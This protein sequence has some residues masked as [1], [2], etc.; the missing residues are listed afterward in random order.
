MPEKARIFWIEDYEPHI[1]I[2]DIFLKAAGHT[3]VRIASSVEEAREAIPSLTDEG[4]QVVIMDGD[5]SGRGNS[6]NDGEILTALIHDT[7]PQIGVIGNATNGEIR[8]ADV[9]ST[10]VG[11]GGRGLAKAIT[12]IAYPI[13]RSPRG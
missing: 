1:E 6:S 5:V 11:G 2:A 12:D 10:K 13:N 9:Q 3:V 4:I 8:G 7:H